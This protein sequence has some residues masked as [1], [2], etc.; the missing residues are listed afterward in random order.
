MTA[1]VGSVT[2]ARDAVARMP[3]RVRF[4]LFFLTVFFMIFSFHYKKIDFVS[5]LFR[6][7]FAEFLFQGLFPLL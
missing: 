7:P 4:A 2:A 3:A 6:P 1:A 5:G